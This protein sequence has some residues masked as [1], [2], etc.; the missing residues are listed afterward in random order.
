MLAKKELKITTTLIIL[1]II[2]DIIVTLLGRYIYINNSILLLENLLSRLLV[3]IVLFRIFKIS[4]VKMIRKIKIKYIILCIVFSIFYSL[5]ELLIMNSLFWWLPTKSIYDCFMKG[6]LLTTNN[7]RIYVFVYSVIMA[8]IL[9]EVVFRGIILDKLLNKFQ[10]PFFP[11][12][13][14]SLLFAVYHLSFTAGLNALFFGILSSVIYIKYKNIR[15]NIALHRTVNLIT[16][17]LLLL[18]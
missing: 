13:I 8:P 5:F 6:P 18:H 14:S 9:E 12:I 3:F 4:P 7:L 17:L 2:S 10:K 15:Y 1:M 16:F 11:V